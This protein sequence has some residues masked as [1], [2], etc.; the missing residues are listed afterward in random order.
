M[1]IKTRSHTIEVG[2]QQQLEQAQG[3]DCEFR[4][5][6][7]DSAGAA[8]DL[9]GA[10]SI[11]M[12]VRDRSNGAAL[13]ARSYSGF[14]GSVGTG[15]VRFQILQADTVDESVQA[16]DVDVYWVDSSGY[17]EQ[18]LVAST[19]LILL[20]V[21]DPDD[22]L[23]VPPAQSISYRRLNVTALKTTGYGATYL[24]LV[25]FN[26]VATGLTGTIPLATGHGGDMIK[27]KVATGT[28]IVSVLP[29][30]PYDRIDGATGVTLGSQES[31]ELI[32]DGETTWM[33]N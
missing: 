17:K 10:Q 25:R 2:E 19:F 31:I 27:I 29:S 1:S 7:T 30:S 20:G 21:S 5:A 4:L 22:P 18:L 28:N 32:S 33:V 8:R 6:F 11:V 16:Y 3:E 9:T 26:T 13:F 23:T 15:A 14:V 24:D 12:T